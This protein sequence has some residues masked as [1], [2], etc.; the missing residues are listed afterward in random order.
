MASL[1]ASLL[2]H[3]LVLSLL[4]CV[5]VGEYHKCKG[6]TT[7]YHLVINKYRADLTQEQV[8][9]VISHYVKLTNDDWRVKQFIWGRDLGPEV[10][11]MTRGYDYGY[12]T[13]LCS[14]QETIDYL[15]DP[16][17]K[18]FADE[19]FPA[20]EKAIAI[21]YV[22][23]HTIR[24]KGYGISGNCGPCN[25]WLQRDAS[26]INSITT[27]P[28]AGEYHKGKD[29][30]PEVEDKAEGYEYGYL[31]TLC[32]RQQ[33]IDYLNDPVTKTFAAEFFPASD[34]NA[35]AINYIVNHT[36]PSKGYGTSGKC[37]PCHV[38]ASRP[39]MFSYP[40]PLHVSLWL[41]FN[42]IVFLMSISFSFSK[43]SGHA[44]QIAVVLYII[45][46]PYNINNFLHISS[47][48]V[49]LQAVAPDT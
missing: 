15:N 46:S 38:P 1:G 26:I 43:V 23:N 48:G 21:N 45:P 49:S 28:A 34:N 30:G 31:T 5:A 14:R 24:S 25:Y 33:T 20:S 7:V 27:K 41:I 8:D 4:L 37:G 2:T 32:S 42:K 44:L 22:V 9:T 39:V 35:I 10:E 17:T 19:F 18:A 40:P 16:V 36:F 6:D 11:D 47:M 29:L 3:F 12:L 13:T